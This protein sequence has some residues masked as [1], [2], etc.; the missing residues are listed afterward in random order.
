[1]ERELK[2]N[3][4]EYKDELYQYVSPDT[5]KKIANQNSKFK[6]E[7]ERLLTLEENKEIDLDNDGVPDR[8]DIDDTRNSVQDV[9][10]LDILKNSASKEIEESNQLVRK[11]KSLSR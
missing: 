9:K 6:K 7:Y 10:D 3:E 4:D 1:M 11:R 8:I 2:L 5:C